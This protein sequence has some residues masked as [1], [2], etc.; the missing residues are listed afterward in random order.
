MVA[1]THYNEVVFEA[2]LYHGKCGCRIYTKPLQI[3][4]CLETNLEKKIVDTD[5]NEVVFVAE[6][7]S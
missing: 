1:D 4:P 7:V 6:L 5:Y 2:D 3:S